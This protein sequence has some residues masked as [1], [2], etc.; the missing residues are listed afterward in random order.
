MEKIVRRKKIGRFKLC[1]VALVR[2][3]LLM[4]FDARGGQSHVVRYS[5][6]L[7]CYQT[8][9]RMKDLLFRPL[10][11]FMHLFVEE[12]VLAYFRKIIQ[13]R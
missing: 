6:D 3:L 9:E 13:F 2:H 8:C 1:Q 10:T 12:E 4:H 7:E 11:K 5:F